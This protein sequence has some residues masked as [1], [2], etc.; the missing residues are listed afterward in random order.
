MTAFAAIAVLLG[1]SGRSHNRI[2]AFRGLPVPIL[3]P[4]NNQ[5]T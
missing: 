4:V 3:N 5:L 1:L 2:C